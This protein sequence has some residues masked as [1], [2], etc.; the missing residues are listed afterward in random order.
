MNDTEWITQLLQTENSEIIGMEISRIDNPVLLHN[1]ALNYNWD[2]GFKL[3]NLIINNGNCELGTA[4][5]LFYNAD[6][7]LLLN[8]NSKNNITGQK[9]WLAF[10]NTLFNKLLNNK[11]CSKKISYQPGLSKVQKYKLK[12]ANPNIPEMFF[13]GVKTKN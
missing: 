13:E 11:F 5:M 1:I 3:L 2:D 8:E 12:K 9:E 10:I 6:G 7:Y 4:L